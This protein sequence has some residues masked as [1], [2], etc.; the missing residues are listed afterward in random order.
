M[1]S[2]QTSVPLCVRD[3][4][5][6]SIGV[7]SISLKCDTAPTSFWSPSSFRL[8][9]K[10]FGF[11][12]RIPQC[13]IEGGAG[14]FYLNRLAPCCCRQVSC[15]HHGMPLLLRFPDPCICL[16][17]VCFSSLYLELGWR[18]C[19]AGIAVDLQTH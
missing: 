9:Q 11:S 19:R 1:A 2:K 5:A 8:F 14:N 3:V 16:C 4:K 13:G 17:F 15:D 10:E 12:A 6:G 18:H 7:R